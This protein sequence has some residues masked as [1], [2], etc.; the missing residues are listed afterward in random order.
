[1]WIGYALQS[2]ERYALPVRRQKSFF[3]FDFVRQK[4][5][6]VTAAQGGV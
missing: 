2:G 3:I 1:L 5:L 4:V 6:H